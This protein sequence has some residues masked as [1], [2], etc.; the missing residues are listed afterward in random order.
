MFYVVLLA[1]LVWCVYFSRNERVGYYLY[2][3]NNWYECHMAKLIRR[4]AHYS[5]R[6][7]VFLTNDKTI[8]T[9]ENNE[10]NENN[11]PLMLMLHGFSADKSIWLKFA[12]LASKDY[13]LLIPDLLGHGEIAYDKQCNYSSYSQ[14]DY[15]KR[16][17]SALNIQVPIYVIGNSMGGMISA[18]L[19]NDLEN[20]EACILLDPAG[21]KTDFANNMHSSKANPFLRSNINDALSFIQKTMFNPPFMPPAVL[22]Y[23]AQNNY[24]QKYDQY[25]HMFHE[26][27]NIDDFFDEP[28]NSPYPK[29]QLIWGMQDALLPVSDSE[30]WKTLIN[31]LEVHILPNIGHM[32]MVECP[33]QV[34]KLM[35]NRFATSDLK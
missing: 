14:A 9:N 7:Y 31:D 5:G 21:A 10:N 6:R 11:K 19:S 22:K 12:K 20:I 18:I 2:R 32:P 29:T 34:Y 28:F 8:G 17:V 3:A 4:E 23:I 25:D 1:F 26:F 30:K 16:L 24:V 33:K 27:F 35:Q 15:V 13:T